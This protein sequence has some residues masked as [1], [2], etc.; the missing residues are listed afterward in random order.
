MTTENEI[1]RIEADWATNDRWKGM[2][3]GYTA[4]DVARLR[5]TVKIEYSLAR[6]GAEKLWGYL[7]TEP[8]VLGVRLTDG[9]TE[10]ADVLF[11]TVDRDL[12][13]RLIAIAIAE[14]THAQRGRVGFPGRTAT[15]LG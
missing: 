13:S 11:K 5:G 7:H 8:F 2:K 9:T 4:A 6:Q 14:I 1:K 15:E 10:I 3:R 12:E